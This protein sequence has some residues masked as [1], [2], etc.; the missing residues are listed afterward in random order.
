MSI[1]GENGRWPMVPLAELVLD[2]T[3]GLASGER[4]PTVRCKS[5]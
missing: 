2:A 3:N 4:T 1:T 5:G